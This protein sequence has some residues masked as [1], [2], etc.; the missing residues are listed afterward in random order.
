MSILNNLILVLIGF[1]FVALMAG[2]FLVI[3]NNMRQGR[4]FRGK[5]ANHVE[6]LRMG[7]MLA[8]LGIDT[9]SYLH[10]VPVHQVNANLK[11]CESCTSTDACDDK[12]EWCLKTRRC[13]LLSQSAKPRRLQ[14][15]AGF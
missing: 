15:G 10:D 8:A 5:V 2:F 11:N 6:S 4:V 1:A 7:R 14:A 9:S 13:R 12:P 3:A